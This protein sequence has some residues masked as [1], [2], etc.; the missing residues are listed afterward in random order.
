MK[1]VY[2]DFQAGCPVDSRVIEAMNPCFKEVGNPSNLHSYGQKSKKLIDDARSKVASLVNAQTHEIFFTSGGT[3]SNNFA[4]IG[5]AIRN[6][7]KGNHII[8]SAIEHISIIN[9]CKFLI[10]EGFKVST[11]PV[12]ETGIVDIEKIKEA[13]TPQT[14]IVSIMHAN[15]EI[16][17]IQPIKEI[18]EIIKSKIYF[19]VDATASAGK[20]PLDVD[21][22]NINLLTLSSNDLYGPQGVGALYIKDG[23]SVN[24]IL[25]G[26]GQ[27]NGLRSGTENLAGI[28]GMGEAAHI[29]QM[30]LQKN[31]QR[32]TQLRDHFI[33]KILERIPESYLNGHP[34]QRLP[35]NANIRFR[36]IEG[37]SILLT[38][39]RRGIAVS[40]GSACTSKTLAASHVLTAIGLPPEEAH[41]SV[42]FSIGRTT[43]QEEIDY[44][45]SELPQIIQSLRK[46][47]PLTPPELLKK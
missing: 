36:F 20:I 40:S 24:P 27:E 21:P 7:N 35:D 5:T 38:L 32:M 25:I 26:G 11:I 15:G 30:E 31:H 1:K 16:G 33:S 47:S 29:S 41:G 23:T 2:L 6:K 43:N 8:I 18:S 34:T 14:L 4:L 39:D 9:I 45:I 22:L 19:H 44:A 46:L 37:E 28:V 13:I 42:L 3:E 17:T 10:K 12:D